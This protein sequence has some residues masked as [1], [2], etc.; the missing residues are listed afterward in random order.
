MKETNRYISGT[1]VRTKSIDTLVASFLDRHASA[2]TVQ[3]ISLGAGTDTRFFRL[4][5]ARPM[6]KHRLIYHETDFPASTNKKINV[7]Q[8]RASLAN[9]IG[10]N[11]HEDIEDDKGSDKTIT[12]NSDTDQGGTEFIQSQEDLSNTQ[13]QFIILNDATALHSSNYHIH[14]LDLRD[15]SASTS[16]ESSISATSLFNHIDCQAPTL[17]LSEMCL[18]YL[19]EE[20]STGVIR[21]LVH[22]LQSGH[23][24]SSSLDANTNRP[25]TNSI[26]IEIV[27]YEPLHP[28]DAFGRTMLENLAARNISL[29]GLTALPTLGSH[30]RRLVGQHGGTSERIELP[31]ST[32]GNS[33]REQD[34]C[35]FSSWQGWSVLDWWRNCI[36]KNEKERLRTL[37]F[38]DEEEEWELLAQHYGIIRAW[39]G[40]GGSISEDALRGT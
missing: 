33:G 36:S 3:I 28:D 21:Q 31:E 40:E 39:C 25:S 14:P 38:V 35:G 34:G 22:T 26:P 1:Y 8:N 24:P 27:L 13:P 11:L 5:E 16:D 37:E 9:L 7:I 29:P 15:I 18:T 2:P 12:S 17:I 32:N 23:V 10:T 6:L 4:M 19:P 20:Q 30:G